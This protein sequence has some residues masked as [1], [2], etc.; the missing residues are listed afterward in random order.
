MHCPKISYPFVYSSFVLGYHTSTDSTARHKLEV[1][2]CSAGE[3]K[4]KTL[5]AGRGG[6]TAGLDDYIYGEETLD[7]D[8][9]FM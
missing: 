7:N 6:G 4:K 1:L 5:N 8:Y 3:G 9:D 2:R